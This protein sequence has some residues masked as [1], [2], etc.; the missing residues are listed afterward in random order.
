MVERMV[1]PGDG[2]SAPRGGS[3]NRWSGTSVPARTRVATAVLAAAFSASILGVAPTAH[4]DDLARQIER[5]TNQVDDL[6][7]QA[8]SAAEAYREARAEQQRL[9]ARMASIERKVKRSE[10]SMG[11]LQASIDAIAVRAYTSGTV[12]PSLELLLS[13]SPGNLLDRSEILAMIGA[14]QGSQLQRVTSTRLTLERNR[15]EIAALRVEQGKVVTRMNKHRRA[16]QSKFAAANRVLNSLKGRARVI[17]EAQQRERRKRQLAEA[18]RAAAAW[19]KSKGKSGSKYKVP[20]GV[21]PLAARALS[22]ALKQVGKPYIAFTEGERSFDCSGLTTAAYRH[23]GVSLPHY[24]RAQMKVT[25]SVSRSNLK[26]GD[27]VFFF[28]RG[29]H[30]VA[31]YIGN[32]KI[33]HAL[34]PRVDVTI[35]RLNDRWEARHLSGFGRVG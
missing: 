14:R 24:S 8:E 3:A 27:L 13:T 30:H 23:A 32:G 9:D 22:Y 20:K 10:K 11:S 7:A 31:M 17:Y 34:N 35:T 21:S 4:A 12:S 29:A 18:R 2:H 33:V 25:R 16:M 1:N 6:Q 28:R 26:P 19:A 5:I 15:G